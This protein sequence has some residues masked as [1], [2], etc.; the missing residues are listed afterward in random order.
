[1]TLPSGTIG[2]LA[3]VQRAAFLAA[4][5]EQM[6][7]EISD[8]R[9]DTVAAELVGD[10]VRTRA[11]CR[12][13]S[14]LRCSVRRRRLR[15]RVLFSSTWG[16]GHVFPMVPLARAFVAA[17]H[18]V[19]WVTNEPTCALVRAA[20][21]EARAGGLGS[22]GLAEVRRRLAEGTAPLPGPA[23]AGFAFPHMFGAWATPA[24]ATDLLETARAWRPD[25]L[26]HEPAE[27]ASALVGAVL[28]VRSLTHSWGGSV[29][30]ELLVAAG[31]KVAPV[32]AAHGL[33]VAPYA[34]SFSST[35][36][37]L[38]PPSV[39]PVPLDHVPDR[40][41]LRP[42]R[43]SGERPGPGSEPAPLA[44]APL[45]YLTF[46]TVHS[47]AS[48]MG[49]A[50][51]GLSGHPVR[52][53][54][55]V[56]RDGDPDAFGPLGENVR[57]ERWASQADVLPRAS[58]VVSHAGSGTVLGALG[59][60]LPQLCLPQAAD[61]F[62]NT[63]AVVARGAGL[64]ITPDRLSPEGVHDAVGRLL[65]EPG[66]RSSAGEVAAEIAAMPAAEDVV[67]LLAT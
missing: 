22:D 4:V 6:R 61:Q 34:G 25:L 54:A 50:L 33:D 21:I 37:D 52:V 67:T 31:E 13:P 44:G 27:L 16:V 64:G 1:M 45:V 58:L 59:L 15:M 18:D 26:L 49:A 35:Y 55:T 39:Q 60:G 63:D 47:S 12:R 38:C 10:H 17:G 3:P 20:G 42:G 11:S 8:L 30:P 24:M 62:R 29:P 46:G 32:W 19:L 14:R 2:N 65:D 41:P 56:G 48:V 57:V 40:Q 5:G 51:S 36:L 43:Y 66:F 53:L 28:G 9:Q 23:R 7:T